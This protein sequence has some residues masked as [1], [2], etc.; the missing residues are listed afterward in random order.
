[1]KYFSV[2]FLFVFLFSFKSGVS[3]DTSKTNN[4][5][6][7]LQKGKFA[8]IFEAGTLFNKTNF[9]EEYLLTAKAHLSGK[10]ALRVSIGGNSGARH[11]FYHD[12][13]YGDYEYKSGFGN[14]NFSVNLQYF[15][16]ISSKVKP[17]VSLGPYGE[18]FVETD[19]EV[20]YY[21]KTF[22]QK[23]KLGGIAS[24]GV[25][26]FVL[27]NLSLIGEYVAVWTGGKE[28]YKRTEPGFEEIYSTCTADFTFKKARFGLSFYF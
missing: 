2:I 9:F 22:T 5:Q 21:K 16:N 13:L 7:S 6:E 8:V 4:N 25:E 17:F 28:F 19:Y 18:Y 12:Q 26:M 11:V 3:Q 23:W 20:P 1:M 27:D 10:L 24:F 14:Y 15:L